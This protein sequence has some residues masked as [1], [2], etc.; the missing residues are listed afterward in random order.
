MTEIFKMIEYLKRDGLKDEEVKKRLNISA[1]KFAK[2]KRENPQLFMPDMTDY[3]VEDALLKR[4]LGFSY[5]EVKEVEKANG[6]EVTRLHKEVPPDVSAAAT[7]LKNRKSD[8]WRDKQE[9]PGG[10]D[11]VTELIEKFDVKAEKSS[12]QAKNN[13]KKA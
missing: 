13:K 1:R 6:T 2:I 3:M 7:W 9:E 8:V 5:T 12:L 10:L 11:K 4:A